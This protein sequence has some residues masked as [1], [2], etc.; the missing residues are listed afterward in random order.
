MQLLFTGESFCSEISLKRLLLIAED[1]R[2]LD[3]PS[4]T[5]ENWGTIGA[6]S[7]ARR[8]DPTG[9]PVYI[10]AESPPSGPA[11]HLYEP[12]I[13]ADINNPEFSKVVFDAFVASNQFAH[14]FVQP[15]ANYGEATGVEIIGALRADHGLLKGERTLKLDG[16]EMFRISSAEARRNTFKT[17]LIEASISVTSAL[18]VAEKTGFLPVSDDPAFVCLLGIRTIG[19]P[20]VGGT[21]RLAPQLGLAVAQAIVP[22][23][24]LAELS[25]PDILKYR[26]K[27]KAPYTSWQIQMNRAAAELSELKQLSPDDISRFIQA[28]VMPTIDEHRIEMENIRDEMFAELLKKVTTWEVPTLSLA[29]LANLGL[30]SAMALFAS[31]LS[32]AIPEVVEYFKNRRAVE[33][34]NSMSFLI[35]ASRL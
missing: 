32:P 35:G 2:F 19:S 9:S 27:A 17:I 13:L 18:L 25:V 4:V 33:R 16:P 22:D 20:Y 31:A 3:R 7:F 12:Y 8:I 28:E 30:G 15:K 26:E 14:K 10:G 21:A 6:D 5:F 29:Y 11:K 23:S 34:K 24:I 1:L